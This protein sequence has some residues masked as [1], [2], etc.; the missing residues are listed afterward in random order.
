[1]YCLQRNLSDCE[2]TSD[3]DT[4][5]IAN[6]SQPHTTHHKPKALLSQITV[7][8]IIYT[9]TSIYIHKK[10]H[11]G[12]C[13][14]FPQNKQVVMTIAMGSQRPWV[15]VQPQPPDYIWPTLRSRLKDQLIETAMIFLV[16][17]K[18]HYCR[19]LLV[20]DESKDCARRQVWNG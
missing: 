15:R 6:S 13:I 16:E 4:L 19:P 1:M 18:R 14:A 12:L 2:T 10:E 11:I 17:S 7:T 20:A 5:S 9:C 3:T 8:T